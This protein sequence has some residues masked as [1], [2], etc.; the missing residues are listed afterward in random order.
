MHPPHR[1]LLGHLLSS[2]AG[3][4]LDNVFR[5]AAMV[6]FQAYAASQ[7]TDPIRVDQLSTQIN[8]L[9]ALIFL[10][11]FVLFAPVAG[12]LG[13][14]LPKHLIMRGA[15]L[16]DLLVLGLGAL[17]VY[18]QSMPLIWATLALLGTA[19]AFFGT[20]KLSAMPELAS[21]ARLALANGLLAATTLVAI[22]IGKGLG[23]FANQQAMKDF[24]ALADLLVSPFGLVLAAGGS[25]VA[26]GLA[27]AFLV[28]VL[29]AVNPGKALRP[30]DFAG[31]LRV[32]WQNRGLTIPS[33]SLA[34]FWGL[35]IVAEVQLV[36]IA[37]N[38]FHLR[39][40]GLAVLVVVLTL[41]IVAGSLLAPRLRAAAFPAG[42]PLVGA[43]LAGLSMII[44]GGLAHQA[45]HVGLP[46]GDSLGPAVAF[47]FWLFL[48]GTGAGLWDVPMQVLLQ[49]R[50]PAGV[51][52]Q[53][54]A[55]V[56]VLTSV[57]MLASVG[58]AFVLSKWGLD[59][60]RIYQIAGVVCVVLALAGS[61]VYR[62]QLGSWA[63]AILVRLVWDLRVHDAG[64]VPAQGGCLIVCNHLSY[65]DG[66]AICARLHRPARFL[67]FSSF[68]RVPVLGGLLRAIG[69]I[70]VAAED[71][72][73]ALLAS[74]EAAV[75]AAKAGECVLIFPEGKLTR[76][77]ST[78]SF[79]GGME[80]I[81]AR[82]GV[83]VIPAFLH[84]LYGTWM[85]RAPHRDR[86]R[87][88]RR[89]EVRFGEPLP[90][91][92]SAAEA[93]QAVMRLGWEAACARAEADRRSLGEAALRL[94]LR[95]PGRIAVRDQLRSLPAWQLAALAQALR[96][97]L[98]LE[99]EERHVGVMLPPGCAGTLVNLA[100]A[101]DG[102]IAVN[103]NHTTGAAQVARM[104]EIAGVRTVISSRLYLRRINDPVLP[105]RVLHAE[106]LLPGIPR[107]TLFRHAVLN[108]VLPARWRSRGRAGEVA[109]VIFSSGSTGDPK[110]VQ[111]THRQVLAQT[112][113]TAEGLDLV[114]CADTVLTP[115]PLFHS[116]G[117]IPG[118]WLGLCEGLGIAAHPDP[119]DGK[120]IGELCLASG[121][122]LLIST[123]TFVRGY[124]RRAEPE[125]FRSLRFSV[126]G[127]ERCPVEL[128]HQFLERYGSRLLEG[129]GCT[130]LCPVV[131]FNQLDVNRDG[132]KE[133]RTRDGSVGRAMPGLQ[134]FAVDQASLTPLPP[135]AVGLLVVRSPSRTLGYLG[136]DDLTAK[137]FVCAGYNTGDIGR[138]DADGFIHITGRLA[139]FAKIGG[140]MVPLDRV[141][142]ELA[143]LVGETVELAV[144]SVS[145]EARGER[146]VVL[147]TGWQG[148]WAALFERLDG[149]PALWRPKARDVKQVPAIPKLGTGKLDLAAL[150]QLAAGA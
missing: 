31:Q 54:M 104:C 65:A 63:T 101:L 12:D 74:I 18:L 108:Q 131:S 136:R 11:P 62:V 134:A 26:I 49:E 142:D 46:A 133:V 37:E 143:A 78:D 22:L 30:F 66:L 150:R 20:V 119:T 25:L 73:R 129:Y 29:P 80:R 100:L 137:A 124:L 93:R 40:Q 139:R 86:P 57:G 38:A 47:G 43:A 7:H 23:S 145:D 122:T 83:P 103:L 75:E 138:V 44:A 58:F 118:L 59:A 77:G 67:I 125:Q 91:T 52:N 36:G 72:R 76:S 10:A 70:P 8:H 17:G 56:G 127:G 45:L 116:F 34:G 35:A 112:R 41:G 96:G 141:Q 51:R 90:P 106:D 107:W 113:A 97:R 123:P 89:V 98:G 94:L 111:F 68:T 19:S 39:S 140:E 147:H 84:G 149:I 21:P 79:R 5:M 102:R 2:F 33:L 128:K 61:G 16:A 69:A 144:S 32:L 13:D 55:A 28:P 117:L 15:R 24:P 53:V 115:L 120:A 48:A 126:V 105:G 1:G 85:S 6:M 50:S 146:L 3:A 148:D 87:L 9:S 82:A 81:A 109:L 135:D 121:A 4:A 130:E 95:R 27:G 132:E 99:A 60:G 42:L 92:V 114:A 110:G 88:R 14:R 71:G 64:R